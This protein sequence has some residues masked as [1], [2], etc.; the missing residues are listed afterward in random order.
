MVSR[1]RNQIIIENHSKISKDFLKY[2]LRVRQYI[3]LSPL[4]AYPVITAFFIT[5][6]SNTHL[7]FHKCG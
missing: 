5:P 2:I 6:Q 4:L 3:C 7:K 1:H